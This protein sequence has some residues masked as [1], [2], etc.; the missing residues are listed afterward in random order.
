VCN[1]R[2]WEKNSTTRSL[3]LKYK[4]LIDV[5]RN[6]FNCRYFECCVLHNMQDAPFAKRAAR[7]LENDVCVVIL[8]LTSGF[9]VT[10]SP[11]GR[12]FFLLETSWLRP[13]VREILEQLWVD[14][15]RGKTEVLGIN[16]L[17]CHFDHHTSY[18]D[19]P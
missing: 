4:K 5:R 19:C 2:I 15:G 13:L 12:L 14:T 1:N 18:R 10:F 9:N 7:R 17:Q 8:S 16:L 11:K 3:V 6:G